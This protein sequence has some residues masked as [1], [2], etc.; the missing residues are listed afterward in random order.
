MSSSS[1]FPHS[2]IK[3]GGGNGKGNNRIKWLFKLMNIP[4]PNED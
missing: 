1:L 2:Q 4:G 3:I